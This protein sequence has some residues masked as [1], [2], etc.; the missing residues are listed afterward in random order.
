M[1]NKSHYNQGHMALNK[2]KKNGKQHSAAINDIAIDR[3]LHGIF[4]VDAVNFLKQLP[5][6]SIQLILIDPPYNLDLDYWDTYENYLDWAKTWLDE[7]YR[8]L[9]D[10]GNCV[11]FGG[12]Q[13]QDLK[14]EIFL[15]FSITHGTIQIYDS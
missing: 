5:D 4:T 11:I 15:K 6:S 10:S 1:A 8:I 9:D 13:Y 14:K 12:F 2:L 7:I 3:T